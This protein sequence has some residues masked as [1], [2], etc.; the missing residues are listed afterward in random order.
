MLSKLP[1]ISTQWYNKNDHR[2]FRSEIAAMNK[3]FP[4]AGFGFFKSDGA[5]YWVLDLSVDNLG[6]WR[7]MVI[8]DENHPYTGSGSGRDS[9][10]VAP[11]RPNI[12]EIK[13][14]MIDAGLERKS[15]PHTYWHKQYGHLLS[16]INPSDVLDT[17]HCYTAV[18]YVL[19]TERWIRNFELE[20]QTQ[21]NN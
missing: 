7:V 18:S 19:F 14:K 10:F 12:R 21:M 11:V 1:D 9:I 6:T 15:V 3:F 13:Q 4:K 8:Y 20:L 16:V 2:L 5:M 17:N